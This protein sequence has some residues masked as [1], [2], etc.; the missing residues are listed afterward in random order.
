M[1][2]HVLEP[3]AKVFAEATARPP[4][5]YEP[6]P[7]GAGKL[8]DDVQAAPITKLESNPRSAQGARDKLVQP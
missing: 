7:E 5:L 4:F 8:L 3:A 2:K 6:G 1:S